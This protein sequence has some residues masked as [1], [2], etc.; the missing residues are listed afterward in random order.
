MCLTISILLIR[1][2]R[3][4]LEV[5]GLMARKSSMKN[6]TCHSRQ[7]VRVIIKRVID[8]SFLKN[9]DDNKGK[10]LGKKGIRLNRWLQMIERGIEWLLQKTFENVGG[11]QWPYIPGLGSCYIN[12][13]STSF[14]RRVP[15]PILGEQV[16]CANDFEGWAEEKNWMKRAHE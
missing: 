7:T 11:S 5:V 10:P 13:L 2:N 16:W 3:V 1:I 6:F 9:R 12:K 14:K 8:R 15:I 4:L